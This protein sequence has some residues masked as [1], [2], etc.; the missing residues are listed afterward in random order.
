MSKVVFQLAKC[1]KCGKGIVFDEV[2]GRKLPF[3]PIGSESNGYRS[4]NVSHFKTCPAVLKEKAEKSCPV[5]AIR[6][7][8]LVVL[9]DRPKVIYGN[10]CAKHKGIKE[11]VVDWFGNQRVV[12]LDYKELRKLRDEFKKKMEEA[13]KA[14]QQREEYG[15]GMA[16]WL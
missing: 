12:T 5:C 3:D 11:F 16:K 14:D 1:K 2:N 13:T 9:K 10:F 6:R 4:S 7:E 15:G 8:G